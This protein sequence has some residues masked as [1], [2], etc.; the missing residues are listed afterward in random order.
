MFKI[1]YFPKFSD[2]QA[3][4]NSADPDQTAPVCNSLCIFWMHYSKE[5]PFCSTFRVITTNFLGVQKFRKFT[6]LYH[7]SAA[8]SFE[9]SFI[10]VLS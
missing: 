1:T 3:W 6:V 8:F 2:G 7:V 4:A 9:N 5:K 10:V